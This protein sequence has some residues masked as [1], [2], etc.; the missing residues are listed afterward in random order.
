MWNNLFWTLRCFCVVSIPSGFLRIYATPQVQVY[1]MPRQFLSQ[2][3]GYPGFWVPS[4][5]SRIFFDVLVAVRSFS[6]F[7][8][9]K[10]FLKEICT[11][12]SRFID[13]EG[14]ATPDHGG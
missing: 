10:S 11:E 2:A 1:V 14:I 5:T 7:T 12:S 6:S 13:R 9:T 3:L 4:R 8:S